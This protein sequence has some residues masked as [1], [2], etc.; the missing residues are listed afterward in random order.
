MNEDGAV[1]ITDAVAVINVYLTGE[2]S[3]VNPALADVNGD[4]SIDITDAVAIINIYLNN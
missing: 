2:T 4:G 3:A 1:D